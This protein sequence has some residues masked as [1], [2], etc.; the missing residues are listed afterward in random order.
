MVPRNAC[1]RLLKQSMCVLAPQKCAAVHGCV[2]KRYCLIAMLFMQPCIESGTLSLPNRALRT[3]K[4]FRVFCRQERFPG[5]ARLSR[6]PKNARCSAKAPS[7][8]RHM[9]FCALA[10]G[11]WVRPFL[12]ATRT[13]FGGGLAGGLGAAVRSLVRPQCRTTTCFD[14]C[15][16]CTRLSGQGSPPIN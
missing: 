5:A 14:V 2:R 7:C 13:D 16:A 3:V 10:G 15:L 6:A 9:F 12:K 1:S 4:D 8:W 11:L